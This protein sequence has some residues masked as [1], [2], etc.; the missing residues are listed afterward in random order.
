MDNPLGSSAQDVFS[1]SKDAL[2]KLYDEKPAKN[3]KDKVEEQLGSPITAITSL[4][5][6]DLVLG[7]FELFLHDKGDGLKIGPD[8][9]CKSKG[10]RGPRLDAWIL[11]KQN[12]CYQ[13]E[14]KNWCASAKGGKR[15]KN[16]DGS[17]WLEAA[18]R[19]YDRYLKHDDNIKAVWKV[20]AE[21]QPWE[22]GGPGGPQPL[23]AFWS[24]VAPPSAN[25]HD[26]IEALITVRARDFKEQIE[27]AGYW[28]PI[29]EEVRIFSASNYLRQSV[30]SEN[31]NVSMPRVRHRLKKLCELGFRSI[32]G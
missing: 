8:Y 27:C 29:A 24:P 12:T 16:G 5:G 28:P 25:S 9:F 3:Q 22:H 30:K 6:E 17:S 14:V 2:I 21:M 32:S 4:I 19:N 31:I 7:L 20:V 15:I 26:A 23:L 18:R 11:T 10:S 1:L 13:A